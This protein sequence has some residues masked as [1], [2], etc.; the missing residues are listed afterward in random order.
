MPKYQDDLIRHIQAVNAWIDRRGARGGINLQ[1]LCVGIEHNGRRIDLYPQFSLRMDDGGLGYT[2]QMGPRTIG[3]VGWFPYRR[4]HWPIAQD[5]QLFKQFARANGLPTPIESR[6]PADL[7]HPFIIKAARSSFGSG[8]RGPYGA[9][10]S[11]LQEVTLQSGE[12]F[13]QLIFGQ[14][15]RAWY[16]KS[17]LAVLEL[18][19]MPRVTGDGQRAF[20]ELVR[21]RVGAEASLPTRLDRI[22]RVQGLWAGAILPV[23]RE[24]IADYRYVSSLNNLVTKNYNVLPGAGG[25]GLIR[26]FAAAG[27]VFFG[28]IPQACRADTVFVVDAIVD[29][30]GK[31]WYLEMNCNSQQHPDIYDR[32]LDDIYAAKT[33]GAELRN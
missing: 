15:A 17:T 7:H 24:V 21:H 2:T 13:E 11:T 1:S 12:Y 28:G 31:V 5:K 33:E 4:R 10:E 8:I 19:D 16:C 25:S 30:D 20:T 23:G 9:D 14:I 27:P 3:F 18:F 32:M 26:Q 22:A 29:A 6:D